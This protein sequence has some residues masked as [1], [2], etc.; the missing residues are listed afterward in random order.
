MGSW[1]L[2]SWA[3]FPTIGKYSNFSVPDTHPTQ[4]PPRSSGPDPVT[5]G[6][7]TARVSQGLQDST[8]WGASLTLGV[9]PTRALSKP[10]EAASPPPQWASYFL[11]FF[12]APTGAGP[13]EDGRLLFGGLLFAEGGGLSPL[14]PSLASPGL[15]QLVSPTPASLSLPTRALSGRSTDMLQ[16]FPGQLSAKMSCREIWSL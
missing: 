4:V 7:R 5:L 15:E 3:P 1:G 13:D 14:T 11:F 9:V 6:E 8:W 12:L 10:Q 2:P 16:G